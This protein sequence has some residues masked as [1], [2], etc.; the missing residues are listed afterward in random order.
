MNNDVSLAKFLIF[1][2]ETMAGVF[3]KCQY[4]FSLV[5]IH[6][7][8]IDTITEIT[9]LRIEMT[10][11]ILRLCEDHIP[12]LHPAI[13]LP[14]AHR[15]LLVADGEVLIE[16]PS[17][18][19]LHPS[20][21]AWIGSDQIAITSGRKGARLYRWELVFAEPPG[22]NASL[23]SAP[24]V[25]T[26]F[27]IASEVEL[28]RAHDWLMRCDRVDF[29]LGAIAYTHVHQGPGIRCIDNG[30]I[31]VETEGQDHQYRVG[32]AWLEVGL[33]PVLATASATEETGFV[34]CLLLPMLS[35]NKSSI[36]YVL[37][38]DAT[39]EKHQRYK[40]FG[41]KFIDLAVSLR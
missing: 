16:F 13:F 15:S 5:D 28:S 29:P 36:R 19:Q 12:P 14:A 8:Y 35:K 18:S 27:K 24:L 11:W 9:F 37:D 40:V 33:S 17:G 7:S 23:Q 20:D 39:K 26:D 41:E 21:T 22:E 30:S 10:A 6:V 32:D 25:R 38:E 31:R 34:R 4:N 3:W 1:L 2:S